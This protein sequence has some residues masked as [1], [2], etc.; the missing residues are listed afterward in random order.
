MAEETNHVSFPSGM[1][2]W[3]KCAGKRRAC[4]WQRKNKRR[5][6]LLRVLV[7]AH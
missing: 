2:V 4:Y 1:R 7:T 6:G 3:L 5:V